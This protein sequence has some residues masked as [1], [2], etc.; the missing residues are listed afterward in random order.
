MGMSIS[1]ER[2]RRFLRYNMPVPVPPAELPEEVLAAFHQMSTD[3]PTHLEFHPQREADQRSPSI[4]QEGHIEQEEPTEQEEII[5]QEANIKQDPERYD[6]D[7]PSPTT[8]RLS[9]L[10]TTPKTDR[11]V[12]RHHGRPGSRTKNSGQ[13]SY[14]M[15]GYGCYE[16]VTFT[17]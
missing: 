2:S 14:P 13:R 6:D 17:P 10:R 11:L 7:Y 4:K 3:S 12:S 1:V 5:A 15:A 8:P 9:I 16:R